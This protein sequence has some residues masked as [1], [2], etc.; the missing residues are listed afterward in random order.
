MKSL[1][2]LGLAVAFGCSTAMAQP[3]ERQLLSTNVFGNLPSLQPNL[4]FQKFT[5]ALKN[6]PNGR[7]FNVQSV[8]PPSPHFAFDNVSSGKT[9]M[10]WTQSAYFSSK[11]YSLTLF[12]Y[13]PFVSAER[14]VQWRALPETVRMADGIYAKLGLK[15]IPCSIIDSNMDFVLRRVPDGDYA[16]RGARVVMVGPLQEIY[17]ASG[18]TPIAIPLGEIARSMETGTVDGGYSYSPHESIGLKLYESAKALIHPSRVR[19]F[20]SIDLLFNLKFW[21]D[22]TESDQA[23]IHDTCRNLVAETLVSSRKL[24]SEAVERYKKAGVV[25]MQL[26]DDETQAMRQKWEEVAAKRTAFEPAFGQLYK[27]LY[28]K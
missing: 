11:E 17:A 16:F 26:P 27:S 28:A 4:A 12:T 25:V 5:V 13:P 20:F 22:L 10:M 9:Q 1:K 21:T 18:I 8:G 14:Y 24:S 23:A 7:G 15:A 19:S 2:L 3:I 6:L